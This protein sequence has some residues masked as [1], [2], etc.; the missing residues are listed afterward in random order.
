MVLLPKVSGCET[1]DRYEDALLLL[2]LLLSP[3]RAIAARPRVLRA[4]VESYSL[5]CLLFHF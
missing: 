5:F 2:D 4:V 3:L 1:L